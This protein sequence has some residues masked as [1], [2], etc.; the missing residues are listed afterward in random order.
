MVQER[1][2]KIDDATHQTSVS[3]EILT[4]RKEKLERM[5]DIF[6]HIKMRIKS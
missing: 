4:F 5:K 2:F 1:K 6:K 3:L